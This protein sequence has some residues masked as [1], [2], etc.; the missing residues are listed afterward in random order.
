MLRLHANRAYAGAPLAPSPSSLDTEPT[1]AP[2]KT[3]G[4]SQRPPLGAPPGRRV[5]LWPSPVHDSSVQRI[6]RRICSLFSELEALRSL[7]PSPQVNALFGELVA[8]TA[9]SSRG[10]SSSILAQPGVRA[11]LPRLRALCASG[12]GLLEHHWFEKIV[13]DAEPTEALKAFPYYDNYEDLTRMEVSAIQAVSK[14]EE[15]PKRILF[16]GSGSLPLTSIFLARDYGFRVDNLD[17]D[18]RAANEGAAL[19]QKLGLTDAQIQFAHS[20][21]LSLSP[22]IL[23][24]Y[25]TFYVAA[26][27]GIDPREKA[28]IFNH[29]AEH[30]RP[31]ARVIARSAFRLRT[32]LYPEIQPEQLEGFAPQLLVHPLNDVV[33]SVVVAQKPDA[34]TA[35]SR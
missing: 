32:L 15:R 21:A 19:A 34:G 27:A 3:T 7:E 29:L 20:D 33:N 2:W 8:L 31:G 30:A 6:A 25:D 14:E 35:V 16:I 11:I 23:A 28:R 5:D 12:E 24:S 17:I 1:R 22:E 13:K 4:L 26:L 9:G 10:E 18:A